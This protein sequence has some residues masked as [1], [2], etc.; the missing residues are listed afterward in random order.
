MAWC[1]S[2]GNAEVAPGQAC[3]KCGASAAPSA[4]QPELVLD[5]SND[6][7]DYGLYAPASLP[8]PRSAPPAAI[9]YASTTKVPS[10][11]PPAPLAVFSSFPPPAV[12]DL[13]A[14]ARL[15]ADYGEP[16]RHWF[17]APLYAWRVIKRRRELRAALAKRREEATRTATE[18]EDALVT[19]AERTRSAAEQQPAYGPALKELRRAEEILRSRDK[20]LAAEQDA[21]SARLAQVDARLAKL[22]EE[23]A[24]ARAEERTVAAEVSAAQA[25][26]ARQEAKLKKAESELR[27]AQKTLVSGEQ[28][29]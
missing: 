10:I 16:P 25:A 9:A 3:P 19:F 22:E 7:R 2:C 12:V 20:V 6:P 21:Q 4:A 1:A 27:T 28:P 13:G 29:E 26:L 11:G 8:R 5:L 15:L 18:A 23:L 24:Q 14:D 17:Q